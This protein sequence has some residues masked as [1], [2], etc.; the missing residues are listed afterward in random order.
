YLHPIV[1]DENGEEVAYGEEGRFAFLDAIALSY[2]GFIVTG[3][4]VRIHETC[5]AC[6]RTTPVLEP[7]I[8]RI[9]GEEIRGCAEEMRKLMLE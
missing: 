6:N 4:K 3:D 5:P 8:E 7:E 1:L 9:R 2:P